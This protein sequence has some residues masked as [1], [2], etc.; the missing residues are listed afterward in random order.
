M[1]VRIAALI[2]LVV[3]VAVGLVVVLVQRTDDKDPDQAADAAP[4]VLR[5]KDAAYAVEGGDFEVVHEVEPELGDDTLALLPDG[6][7]LVLATT[8]KFYSSFFHLDLVDPVT[9]E[10]ERLPAPWNVEGPE[11][12]PVPTV[13]GEDR[14]SVTW[15]YR[16]GGE[17]QD[18][19][20]TFDLATGRPQEIH[21]RPTP[22][23]TGR[24]RVLSQSLP[25]GDG[26]YY[27]QTGKE[28]CGDG[29]C[30]DA[31]QGA[32]WSFVPGDRE[33][34]RELSGVVDFTVSGDLLAWTY[35]DEDDVH[36]RDLASGDEHSAPID[37]Q[38][39]SLVASSQLVVWVCEG[40]G[41]NVV[42]D[43]QA[44]PLV[45]LELGHAQPSVGERWVMVSTFAYDTRTGRLL[46]L[47]DAGDWSDY[48]PPVI[49]DQVVVPLGVADP[50][51][52]SPEDRFDR[53]GVVRLADREDVV[54]EV[55]ARA[56]EPFLCWNG[57][58]TREIDSCHYPD[59]RKGMRWLF[60][61]SHHESCRE[62]E[63][64]SRRQTFVVACDGVELRDGTVVDL[65]FLGWGPGRGMERYYAD[66]LVRRLPAPRRHTFAFQ[67]TSDRGAVGVLR[68]NGLFTREL[69]AEIHADDRDELAA[70]I[71]ALRMRPWSEF[72]G[73][74]R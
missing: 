21:D 17:T 43:A 52:S 18:R 9:G 61:D 38:D 53:W 42:L 47:Y 8:E 32:L 51:G 35:S 59:G 23:L 24:Q 46:R 5:P 45:E 34:R 22:R 69:S 57:R 70:S 25:A 28:V 4:R 49:D 58:T 71:R 36:V 74:L 3:G 68:Y 67:I 15:S 33:P 60:A 31:S 29:E 55:G 54:G 41:R 64:D 19:V 20:L 2:G 66:E 12:F 63:E 13:L 16:A 65:R 27:F 50:R 56:P 14:L 39:G 11:T 72:Q 73:R 44:R 1:R 26:R 7:L 40:T 6:R 37:C 62:V 10:R 30:S 48:S